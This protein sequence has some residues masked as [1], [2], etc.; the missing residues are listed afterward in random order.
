MVLGDGSS[1]K[2]WTDIWHPIG[3][4]IEVLGERAIHKM[5]IDRHA[6]VSSV[7]VNNVWRFRNTRDP[8]IQQ[9]TAQIQEGTVVLVH[10][11]QD[12][13]HWKKEEDTYERKFYASTT[14]ESIRVSHDQ[15]PWDKLVL[16]AQGVPRFAFITWLAVR[17]RLSTG[18]RMRAWGIVQG[19]PFC[20]ERE[21]SRDHLFFACPYTYTL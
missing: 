12:E 15:V 20:G 21:E 16:F 17:D 2:F 18:V 11:V 3:R 4:L 5:G 14:L 7:F 9:V 19:C 10:G 6:S 13:A 1:T 8:A